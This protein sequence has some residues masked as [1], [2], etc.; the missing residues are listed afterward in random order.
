MFNTLLVEPLFNLLAL[1]YAYVPGADFGV[2]IIILTV[3][4][5]LALW[6]IVNKQLHSQKAMQRIAPD[7]KKVKEKAKG[8]RTK[9]SQMLMELYKE[10]GINPFASL[11]PL[12]VQLPLLFALFIVLR[13]IVK[14][15][16]IA[17]FAYDPIANLSAIRAIIE[18]G[19]FRPTFLGYFDLAKSSIILS[20]LAAGVQ[21]Y[22]AKQLMPKDMSDMAPEARAISKATITLFPVLTF[23]VGLTLPS[24]LPLFWAA[25]SLIAILQQHLVLKQDVEEMEGAAK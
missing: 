11:V 18:G 25:T 2:A 20:A 21:A 23:I 7:V 10:K 22:Q 12:L 6:P 24:A 5:R 15:G 13:D 4:V 1:I 3:I 17:S 8:D 16:E 9:E 19:Q 14:P